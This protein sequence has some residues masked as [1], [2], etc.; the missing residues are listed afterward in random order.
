M[1]V[2]K[3]LLDSD[4]ATRWQAMRDLT[5]ATDEEVPREHARVAAEG[6]ARNSIKLHAW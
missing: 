2:V 5:D 4:P 1:D 3:W 6:C